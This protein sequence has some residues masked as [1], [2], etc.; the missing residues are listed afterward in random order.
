MPC[1]VLISAGRENRKNMYKSG[2][3]RICPVTF[4]FSSTVFLA[5]FSHRNLALFAFAHF[6]G[7]SLLFNILVSFYYNNHLNTSIK[8]RLYSTFA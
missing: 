6:W 8:F 4:F 7:E 1:E 3:I 5:F 2:K